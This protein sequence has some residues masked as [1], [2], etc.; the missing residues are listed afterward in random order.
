MLKFYH[1]NTQKKTVII[2]QS[3]NNNSL[4]THFNYSINTDKCL[5]WKHHGLSPPVS[6]HLFWTF[7]VF[8]RFPYALLWKSLPY[9]QEDALSKDKHRHHSP[10]LDEIPDQTP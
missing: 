6:W 8:H 3:A 7:P 4:L 1:Q 9:L 10:K 5:S 2:I